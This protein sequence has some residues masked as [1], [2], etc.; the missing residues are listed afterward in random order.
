[1]PSRVRRKVEPVFGWL[2]VA[3]VVLALIVVILSATR[4]IVKVSAELPAQQTR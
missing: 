4:P 3:F 1:M 2:F